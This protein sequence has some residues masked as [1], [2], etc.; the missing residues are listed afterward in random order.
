MQWRVFLTLRASRAVIGAIGGFVLAWQVLSIRPFFGILWPPDIIGVSSGPVP[1]QHLE[2]CSYPV[3]WRSQ[4]LLLQGCLFC[5]PC[6]GIIFHNR[7]PGWPQHRTCRNRC[8]Q[9]RT[10]GA[11][12]SE[13][14]RRSG[15]TTGID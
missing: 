15:K 3:L 2:F 4:S 10:D 14:N 5:Y 12:L 9:S 11:G 1:V 13:I 8:S 7:R 6:T